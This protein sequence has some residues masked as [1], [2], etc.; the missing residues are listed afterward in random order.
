M[1]LLY[2]PAVLL[3][4]IAVVPVEAQMLTPGVDEAF[5]G[6]LSSPSREVPRVMQSFI[7]N[8]FLSDVTTPTT[9]S[10]LSFRLPGVANTSYPALGDL[11]FTRYEITLAEPSAAAAAANALTSDTF[12][13]NMSNAVLVRSGA[14][15]VPLGS[16]TDNSTGPGPEG[17][18]EFSFVIPFT[19]NYVIQP[20][21]D[22]VVLLRHNGHGD[23]NGVETR[24]N[25][26]SFTYVSGGRVATGNVD[27]TSG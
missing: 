4:A 16:F 20:G 13:D 14:L 12:A 26:D 15:N 24:W 18:A 10:G 23:L 25:F 19:T 1:R 9:I 21:Q 5:N 6:G 27:A 2:V 22:L 11:N 8:S 7:D 3:L 17:S